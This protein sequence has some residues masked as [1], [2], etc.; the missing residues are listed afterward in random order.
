MTTQKRKVGKHGG[1]N[2]CTITGVLLKTSNK[3]IIK[4]CTAENKKNRIV[5]NI[6]QKNDVLETSKS[7]RY[8]NYHGLRKSRVGSRRVTGLR[9]TWFLKLFQ[10]KMEIPRSILAPCEI[11][12]GTLNLHFWSGGRLKL[13]IQSAS[14]HSA[15]PGFCISR[16]VGLWVRL[17]GGARR[18]KTGKT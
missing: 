7:Q 12:K 13:S 18:N 5:S 1:L 4:N 11:R 15:G 9:C 8:S 3:N 6:H 10:Q 14:A 2:P 17:L 16:F